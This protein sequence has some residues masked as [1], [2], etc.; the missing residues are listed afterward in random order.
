[1]EEVNIEA[2]NIR[3]SYF[4]IIKI[5]FLSA[6]FNSCDKEKII[7]PR[8][9][10]S[11]VTNISY[12]SATTGGVISNGGG[13]Y[14]T[15]QGVCWGTSANPTINGS[16]TIQAPFVGSYVSQITGLMPGTLYYVR[17][18]AKNPLGIGYSSQLSFT[19]LATAVPVLTTTAISAI[20][21]F[22]ATGGGVITSDGGSSVTARGICWSTTV[23]PTTALTTKTTNGTGTGTFTSSMT[24]LAS[25]TT[26]YVRAYA[27]NSMGTSYGAQVSFNTLGV[28]VLT[29]TAISA[30]TESTATGGGNITSDGGSAVT[31]RG[32]C[33]STVANPTTALST[34]TTNGT[35]T[36]TY[37]SALT[38]LTASTTYYVRAYA[39]NS[40]GTAYGTQVTF[41][42]LGPLGVTTTAVSAITATT[43]TGGGNV[44]GDG[45]LTV[46]ARGVCW[47]TTANPT[48]AL[49][50]K[51]A[52]GTGT[53]TYT[54]S[55]TNL[56]P[57]T[58][59]YIRSY[60][61]NS[62]S[63]AYGN[64]LTFTTLGP[65]VVT[66]ATTS[67]SGPTTA[68]GGGNVTSD[69]GSAV[70]DRGVCWSTS[71]NPTVSLTTK[72]TDGSGTGAFTS[73]LTGLTSGVTYYIRA[74][75]TNLYGT[76]Y[77][78]QVTL[79]FVSV[80]PT[81]G[82]IGFYPFTGNANDASGNANNATVSGPLLTANRSG[83][84]NSAYLFDGINDYIRIPHTSNYNFQSFT[85]GLW[86]KVT[87][88]GT[89]GKLHWGLIT[90]NN[91][92]DGYQDQFNV[93]MSS[94]YLPGVRVGNGSTVGADAVGTASLNDG[95][96]HYLTIRLDITADVL[97]LFVD[98]IKVKTVAYTAALVNNTSPVNIGYWAGYA[99][100]FKGSIDNIRI[101]NRALTDLEIGS[102]FNE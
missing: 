31:V 20:T 77:G 80:P 7:E 64:Q 19:T 11:P 71:A 12:T 73:T 57:S 18:Y 41:N 8:L 1:M 56:T 2:M 65:P 38:G 60:A 69:G 72:T 45:G 24:G 10:I 17:A 84:A 91:S 13:A 67:A 23:N 78:S 52:N 29:T 21:S 86:V 76:S 55:I 85:I 40:I 97:D 90:K 63:T 89:A 66:T 96:W 50:T 32:I 27:T 25:G 33:W 81:S 35:G 92:P 42:T 58:L 82:L 36:G 30:I 44:T 53:G 70:T 51:T 47:S 46:S 34:K 68:D 48:T 5:I 54:S 49:A 37:T 14:M 98:N 22:S 100:Y 39:T 9:T 87:G 79:A 74:Y 88:A 95:N 4:T 43:A 6:F 16:K 93:Y 99:N 102:L 15:E 59:Y 61:T 101:Y 26:Y 28:P 3:N 62:S 94:A 83:T 75:A